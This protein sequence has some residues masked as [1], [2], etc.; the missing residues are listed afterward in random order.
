MERKIQVGAKDGAFK[1]D[2]RWVTRKISEVLRNTR[3]KLYACKLGTYESNT[4]VKV[5]GLPRRRRRWR[6]RERP[7]GRS[8][9]TEHIMEQKAHNSNTR[10][11]VTKCDEE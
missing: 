9:T 7:G 3:K 4:Y 6:K 10:L 1:M 5:G 2:H 8:D 11:S